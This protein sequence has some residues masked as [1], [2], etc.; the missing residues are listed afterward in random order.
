MA[1]V[2]IR[3]KSTG[4]FGVDRETYPIL[5]RGTENRSSDIKEVLYVSRRDSPIDE[6]EMRALVATS[7]VNNKRD[8]LTGVL[9]SDAVN[10]LQLFEGEESK[11]DALMRRI[12]SDKRHHSVV[13]LYEGLKARRSYDDWSV[14]IG[15]SGETDLAYPG[16][17][18]LIDR[19]Y[20]YRSD[21]DGVAM[22][23]LFFDVAF[24]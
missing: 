24:G 4:R 18:K 19:L 20:T 5:N 3:S 14:S 22:A 10:F 15:Y 9:F 21:S 7:L 11:V 8:E 23:K 1:I 6:G 17:P 16:F 12:R 13:I 2:Y